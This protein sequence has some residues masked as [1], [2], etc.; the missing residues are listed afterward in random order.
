MW[1]EHLYLGIIFVVIHLTAS[2]QMRRKDI[3]DRLLNSTEYDPRIAPD[4]EKDYATEV[5]VQ[6]FVIN[7]NSIN[8][9]SMDY[10]LNVFL[11]Q[12]WIDPRLDFS[13]LSNIDSLELDQ[14]RIQDVWVPDTYFQ[15]EK[16][17][18]F[19]TVTVP[20]KLLHIKNNGLVTYSV[21]LSLTLSCMMDLRF[22]PMDDQTCSILMES[23]G[24]SIENV[25]LMWNPDNDVI[26]GAA[27][28]DE[29]TLP[30]FYFYKP[31]ETLACSTVNSF[32][33]TF[34][35]LEAKLFLRRN[36]GY[37][38]SQVFIPSMLI[39]MLS[40][41][42]FWI[43]VEVVPARVSLGVICVLTMTTQSSGLR[44][45][46]PRV[47]YIKAIDI[48]MAIGLLF[49]FAALLEYAYINVQTRKHHK[50][51]KNDELPEKSVDT[52]HKKK[53][54]DLMKKARFVDKVSRIAFPVAYVI[55]NIVFWSVYLS[56]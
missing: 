21:R 52:E 30:K 3:L 53:R 7:I 8:E 46:L 29:Q 24:Y 13:H 45:S 55:F 1:N 33:V 36:L 11:R 37:Y 49:V 4:F 15:N 22:Y 43:H 50:Q 32:N 27:K 26:I 14:R 34:S 41:L 20:N 2:Q 38:M 5:D 31:I 28:D 48:W 35:C 54:V 12:I 47:S 19:H 39:V 9:M 18:T 40:W 25:H 56:K 51:P 6:L 42:S 16:S 23:F 10:K 44:N 17:A